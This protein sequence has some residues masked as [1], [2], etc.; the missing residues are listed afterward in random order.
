MEC[1]TLIV[2]LNFET[3]ILKSSLC[4]SSDAYI[5]VKMRITVNGGGCIKNTK[6]RK[7]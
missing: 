1:I 6:K 7:R 2:K 5:L 4:D 3:S